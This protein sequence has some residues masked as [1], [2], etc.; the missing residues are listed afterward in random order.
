ML[1]KQNKRLIQQKNRTTTQMIQENYQNMCTYISPDQ[2]CYKFR[3]KYQDQE[4]S[5][6][7]DLEEKNL[8]NTY[9][10]QGSYKNA[11]DSKEKNH[12]E[13]SQGSEGTQDPDYIT[14]TQVGFIS[15]QEVCSRRTL[16]G[17]PCQEINNHNSRDSSAR[18]ARGLG[19]LSP[20]QNNEY[21]YQK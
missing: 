14:T 15:R 7:Q 19:R 20:H 1:Y 9:I 6:T 18:Q 21:V 4:N 5:T 11:E 17:P 12:K 13:I 10:T 3:R 16:N 2:G 8:K